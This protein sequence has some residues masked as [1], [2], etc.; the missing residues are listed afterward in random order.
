M[1]PVVGSGSLSCSFLNNAA[2]VETVSRCI[3]GCDTG[4]WAATIWVGGGR[5]IGILTATGGREGSEIFT[6]TGNCWVGGGTGAM[7]T[8]G[9]GSCGGK[10][11][12]M[13]GLSGVVKLTTGVGNTLTGGTGSEM[14]VGRF[15]LIGGLTAGACGGK[16]I[17]PGNPTNGFMVAAVVRGGASGKG[18]G[19][20]S[21]VVGGS[22]IGKPGAA[23]G[24]GIPALVGAKPTVEGNPNVGIM[25]ICE[26]IVVYPV[27]SFI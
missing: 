19:T 26:A 8:P 25:A 15:R 17:V 10:A 1:A 5:T 7:P 3:C 9:G 21:G 22:G 12:T 4:A 16:G 2:G 24:S 18:M 13:G 23:G 20:C 11:V 6:L 27:Q 14:V